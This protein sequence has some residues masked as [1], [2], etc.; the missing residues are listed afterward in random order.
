[1][2]Q[3]V[4]LLDPEEVIKIIEA[5][6]ISTPIITDAILSASATSDI[7]PGVEAQDLHR[8]DFIWQQTH[9]AQTHGRQIGSDVGMGLLVP[10]VKITKENG[11]T[12]VRACHEFLELQILES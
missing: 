11:T 2:A 6:G 12:L 3:R 10:A 1:M 5:D 8:D 7:G 4:P 9:T